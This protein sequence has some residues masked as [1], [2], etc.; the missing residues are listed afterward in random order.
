MTERSRIPI[1][2]LVA[3]LSAT[4]SAQSQRLKDEDLRELMEETKKD[5]ERFTDGIA[6]QY[7]S[8]RIRTATTEVLV[9]GYL[10]D[11]KKNAETMRERFKEDYAAGREVM[12]FLRQA[13]AIE[14]R[15]AS[16][17]GLFGAEKEWPRLRG[18]LGRLSREYGIDWSASPESWVAMRMND[19]E[20]VSA[21]EKFKKTGESFEKSLASALEHMTNVPKAEVKNVMT[22]ID[23][24]SSAGD[25]LKD[26]AEDG[27]EGTAEL[28]RLKASSGDIRSFLEKYG[29]AGSVGSTF[30]A[31]QTD[32]ATVSSAFH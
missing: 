10:K 24:L 20:L 16:G 5:V 9:D 29:L 14:D 15:A 19:R 6:S 2:I 11:L 7:R 32:L 27:R 13:R 23:R 21:I 26:A 30:R 1:L 12:T 8:A 22:S 25:D 18:T 4:A 3:S 28:A 31:L 17:G